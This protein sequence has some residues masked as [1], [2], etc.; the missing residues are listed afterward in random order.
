MPKAAQPMGG[1]TFFLIRAYEA[2]RPGTLLAVV[3]L[4]MSP[5]T[6]ARLSACPVTASCRSLLELARWL[7]IT[8]PTAWTALG[9]SRR[10]DGGSDPNSSRK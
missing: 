5:K 9:V 1:S 8:S 7:V 3:S 10:R 6:D 4:Q 2:L